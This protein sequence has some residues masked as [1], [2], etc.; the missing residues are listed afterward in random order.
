M[1]QIGVAAADYDISGTGES[2][3]SRLRTTWQATEK[4]FVYVFGGNSFQP[5]AGG[6]GAQLVYRLGYGANWRVLSRWSLGAQI[7]HDY[8]ESLTDPGGGNSDGVRHF[9][10][11]ETSYDLT[12]RFA[13]SLTGDYINDE[14]EVDQAIVSLSIGY[15]Y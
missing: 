12:R 9:F 15:S 2:V 6:G 11:A 7:L 4:V 3:V 1:A 10:T 5:R 8:E 14:F 13:L